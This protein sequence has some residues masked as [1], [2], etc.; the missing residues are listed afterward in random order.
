MT[1]DLQSCQVFNLCTKEE[2]GNSNPPPDCN[3]AVDAGCRRADE[4]G[5]REGRNVTLGIWNSIGMLSSN[6]QSRAWVKGHEPKASLV[7]QWGPTI[8]PVSTFHPDPVPIVSSCV[9]G[10]CFENLTKSCSECAKGTYRAQ[11]SPEDFICEECPEQS[12]TEMAG[13]GSLENCKCQVPPTQISPPALLLHCR[14]I[15]L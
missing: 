14:I 13:Q 2:C 6:Y 9:D 5:R 12:T 3:P 1:H 15:T 4:K 10:Y 7:M 11:E 8:L